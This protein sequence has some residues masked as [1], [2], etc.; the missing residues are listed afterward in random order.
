M[1]ADGR[2]AVDVLREPGK[3]VKKG[4][5]G[6]KYALRV[7]DLATG[8]DRRIPLDTY[9]WAPLLISPDGRHVSAYIGNV[10]FFVWDAADGRRVVSGPA[11]RRLGAARSPPD[12]GR[13]GA[14][15]VPSAGLGTRPAAASRTQARVTRR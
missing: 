3:G 14:G 12:A 2:F 11:G 8:K 15:L 4:E 10:A 5:G 1:S 6:D 13:S 9:P 7:T